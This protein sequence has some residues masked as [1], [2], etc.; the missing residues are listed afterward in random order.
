MDMY[1]YTPNPKI[2]KSLQLAREKPYRDGCSPTWTL[3]HKYFG[4]YTRCCV[5]LRN[6]EHVDLYSKT[7]LM[8][9]PVNGFMF[10]LAM[11]KIDKVDK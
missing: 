11:F 5:F 7:K 2:L 1:R 8:E 4:D 3:A 6:W 10:P 9:V